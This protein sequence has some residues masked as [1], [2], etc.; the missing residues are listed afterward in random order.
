MKAIAKGN[1]L[2]LRKDATDFEITIAGIKYIG[3]MDNL[4]NKIRSSSLDILESKGWVENG[5]YYNQ[6][7]G[8][9]LMAIIANA[10][11][12]IEKVVK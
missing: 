4:I 8:K 10:S 3:S 1:A 6:K 11:D 2:I 12:I 5:K 7:P 9:Y